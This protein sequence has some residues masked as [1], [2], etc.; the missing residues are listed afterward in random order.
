LVR[1]FYR[2]ARRAERW[3]GLSLFGAAIQSTAFAILCAVKNPEDDD[4]VRL[5]IQL[6]HD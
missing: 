5:E 4:L 6:M 3:G 2:I 1:G